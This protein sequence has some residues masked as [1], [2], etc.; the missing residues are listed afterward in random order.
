MRRKQLHKESDVLQHIAQASAAIRRKH[1]ELKLGKVETQ[2]VMDE[3]LKPVTTPLQKLVDQT[4]LKQFPQI[5][6]WHENDTLLQ[7]IDPDDQSV[8]DILDSPHR[9]DSQRDANTAFISTPDHTPKS[10]FKSSQSQIASVDRPAEHEPITESSTVAS[11][12]EEYLK[13]LETKNIKDLDVEYGIRRLKNGLKL[14]NANVQFT[15]DKMS[16]FDKI[17]EL[18]PGLTSLIFEKGSFT[19]T[20]TESDWNVY[21]SLIRETSAHRKNYEPLAQIRKSN[22]PKFRNVIKPLFF[23]SSSSTPYSQK[24]GSALL[25][26]YMLAPRSTAKEFDYIY[27]DDPNELVDRLRLLMASQAAGNTSHTNEIFSIIEEL[28]EAGIVY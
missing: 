16:I 21:S 22:T 3:A 24:S 23:P 5:R 10:I 6:K 26:K 27:W 7:N 8:L 9:R 11:R 2:R 15:G 19:T 4:D 20:P 18:T 25:P 28:R 14:G 1:K 13:K 12:I 17:Y